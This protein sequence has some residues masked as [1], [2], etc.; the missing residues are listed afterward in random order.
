MAKESRARKRG[1]TKM[2]EEEMIK[3]EIECFKRKMPAGEM[4]RFLIK[5]A[6]ESERLRTKKEIEL[7]FA[8]CTKEW[9]PNENDSI[10]HGDNW[11]REFDIKQ[12]LKNRLETEPEKK[13]GEG[14]K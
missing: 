8:E 2:N 1:E 9:K 4:V 12:C 14:E 3:I 11:F 13:E 6:E 5:K 10:E 7:A